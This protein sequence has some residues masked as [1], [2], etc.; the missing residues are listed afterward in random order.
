MPFVDL[1]ETLRRDLSA[2]REALDS[3]L[4]PL[5]LDAWA[6][7]TPAEGWTIK[8]TVAHL[9]RTDQAALIAVD[10]PERFRRDFD[11]ISEAVFH[12]TYARD[13]PPLLAAWRET[14]AEVTEKVSA[15][16]RG[17]KIVW[18]GLPLS[19][20]WFLT[21]RLMETWAHGQDIVDALGI[22]RDPT[23]RLRH[24]A[25]LGVRTRGWSY[26]LRGRTCPET[27]VR[28]ELSGPGGGTWGPQDAPDA[29]RGLAL[30]FCLLV[31]QRRHRADVAV[32]AHGPAADEWLDIAQ[33]YAGPVGAGRSPGQFGQAATGPTGTGAGP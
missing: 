5:S 31:T 11:A 15:V 14:A 10:D 28:V 9:H 29:V 33:V 2:E 32:R 16:P 13:V 19:P 6:T 1:L 20:M 27:P 24:I 25:D 12:P 8:D 21:A 3:V 23:D 22:G 30:D 7:P 26:T 18:L 17:E 4:A